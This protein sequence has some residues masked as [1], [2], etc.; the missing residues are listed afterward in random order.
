[1]HSSLFYVWPNKVNAL[2]ERTRIV[3]CT[4]QRHIHSSHTFAHRKTGDTR[5]KDTDNNET[6]T[7]ILK[8]HC[9]YWIRLKYDI[10]MKLIFSLP[11]YKS[12]RKPPT[13]RERIYYLITNTENLFLNYLKSVYIQNVKLALTVLHLIPNHLALNSFARMLTT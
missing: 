6:H 13:L 5:N 9:I 11:K 12:S 4:K 10:N 2:R 7:Q 8:I 1:M 3:K